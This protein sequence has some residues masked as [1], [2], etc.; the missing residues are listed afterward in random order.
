MGV[1]HKVVRLH[2]KHA[3]LLISCESSHAPVV[4]TQKHFLRRYEASEPILIINHHMCAP[5][6]PITHTTQY[7]LTT[8][9]A[10]LSISANGIVFSLLEN[11]Q[12]RQ[13]PE[14]IQK[15]RLIMNASMKPITHSN[16]NACYSII[17]SVLFAHKPQVSHAF[18]TKSW[19]YTLPFTKTS[20]NV[21][22]LT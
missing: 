14:T 8:I 4:P 3:S 17:Y 20:T 9:L 5:F 10:Q 12:L 18:K 11:T 7:R 1:P 13:T 21:C 19:F 15:T 6:N 2:H 22:M 16:N